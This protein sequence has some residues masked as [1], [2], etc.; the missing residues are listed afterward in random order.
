MTTYTCWLRK[1][2]TSSNCQK[3]FLSNCS[4]YR[5]FMLILVPGNIFSRILLIRMKGKVDPKLRDQQ[6]WFCKGRSCTDQISILRIITSYRIELFPLCNL[7]RFR[8]VMRL[9]WQRNY[10]EATQTLWCPSKDCKYHQEL[11]R[12]T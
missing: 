6:T 7:Y 4:N 12:M 10:L 5:Q 11:L 8:E 2:G 3:S 1:K 9:S